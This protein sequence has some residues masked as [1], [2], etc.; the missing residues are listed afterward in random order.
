MPHAKAALQPK[1]KSDRRQAEVES[2]R[3]L[4]GGSR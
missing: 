4:S 3:T 1:P 2:Q